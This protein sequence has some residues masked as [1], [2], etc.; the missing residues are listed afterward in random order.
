MKRDDFG[1]RIDEIREL[2]T[3]Y[4][5]PDLARMVQMGM[6][7]PQK[8]LMAGM[9]IDRIAQSAMRPPQTTVV[10]DV[11]SPQPPTT[12]QGQMPPGIMAAPGAPPPS[13]GVAAL[14]SGITE[15]AGGGIV[16]FAD[17]GQPQPTYLP[18][19][20]D[21]GKGEVPVYRAKAPEQ[22]DLTKAAEMRRESERL[23]GLNPT[24]YEDLRKDVMADKEDFAK[25]KNEAKGMALLQ[26]GFGLMGARQGQ[27]FQTASTAA[28][29][30]LA[31]YG[32]SLKEIKASEKEMKKSLRDLKI[33]EAAYQKSNADKDLSRVEEAKKQLQANEENYVKALNDGVKNKVDLFKTKTQQDTQ[34][35]TA[36]IGAN[37]QITSQKIAAGAPGAEQKLLAAI[38]AE[39]VAKNPENP[40]TLGETYERM[41]TTSGKA[42]ARAKYALALEKEWNDMSV[43]EKQALLQK[44]PKLTSDDYIKA[45][46]KLFDQYYGRPGAA[47]TGDG[48]VV[49]TP[50]GAIRFNTQAEA[51]AYRQQVG[52]K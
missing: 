30:A 36:E 49:Q 35:R 13:A 27:E 48:V 4:S 46:M 39:E 28:Q 43:I 31:S 33:A 15:M 16:A 10:E 20:I 26:F 8:A 34:I 22:I 9:M 41:R 1:V 21:I 38:H 24:L 6:L 40:P 12:A 5:K 45:K 7:E 42:E 51:D 44:N 19:N 29:Q 11:L 37:A 47:P 14:P 32:S 18:S 17:G 50:Q 2:A 52:L 23:A 3:K 25:Q